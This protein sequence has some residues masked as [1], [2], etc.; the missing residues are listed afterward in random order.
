ML[1]KEDF[2]F[3]VGYQG[4]S[5]LVDSRAKKKYGKLSTAELLEKGLLRSAFSSAV[6]D[7][8]EQDMQMVISAYNSLT[9][10]SLESPLEMKR[11]LGI[12]AVPGDISKVLSL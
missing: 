6:Y 9:G 4:D 2:V 11:L 8:N 7:D 10:S 1:R 5:A 3:C 12:F